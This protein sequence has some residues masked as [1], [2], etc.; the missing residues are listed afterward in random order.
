MELQEIKM[1]ATPIFERYGITRASVFGSASRGESTPESDIDILVKLGTKMD[2]V[3]YIQF[4]DA[5]A[6]SL[7]RDVDV[8]TESSVSPYL[9]SYIASDLR[10]IYEL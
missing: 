1:K 8:V 4:R 5:L 3:Q 10:P 9:K 7:G 6:A 2:L